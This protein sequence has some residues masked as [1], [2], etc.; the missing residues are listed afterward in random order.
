MPAPFHIPTTAQNQMTGGGGGSA[1]MSAIGSALGPIA[2]GI[3]NYMGASQQWRRHRKEARLNRD[4]QKYMSNTAVSRRMADMRRAGINPILAAKFD[5]STPAGAMAH[6]STNWAADAMAGASTAQDLRVKAET[7]KNMI[8]QRENINSNTRVNESVAMLNEVLARQGEAQIGLIGSS[9]DLNIVKAERERIAKMMDRITA[10]Q[11][12]WLFGRTD[13]E[14]EPN[15]HEKI[16][17][18]VTQYGLSKTAATALLFLLA[19]GVTG[20][21]DDVKFE[22]PKV[23]ESFK[24]GLQRNL[25]NQSRISFHEGY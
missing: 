25:R 6:A 3:F 13:G 5:A 9:K 18:M 16:R 19:G 24:Q 4:F 12:R 11:F 15:R 10:Q 7:R 1:A 17:W 21:T 22:L 23:K 20:T 2:G 14:S 8:A